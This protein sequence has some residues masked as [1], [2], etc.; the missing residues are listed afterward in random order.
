MGSRSWDETFVAISI[1]SLRNFKPILV[2]STL[3]FLNNA[4]SVKLNVTNAIQYLLPPHFLRDHCR[5]GASAVCLGR[6]RRVAGAGLR[7]ADDRGVEAG[8]QALAIVRARG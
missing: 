5:R 6:S 7:A 3:N 4:T 8:G 1:S 2:S